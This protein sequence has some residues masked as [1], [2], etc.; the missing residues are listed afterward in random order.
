MPLY[1]SDS[2]KKRLYTGTIKNGKA[3]GYGKSVGISNGIEYTAEGFYTSETKST[4][5]ISGII[6]S[7]DGIKIGEC[8]DADGKLTG[9][10]MREMMRENG[11]KTIQFGNFRKDGFEGPNIKMKDT[12]K[13]RE[14]FKEKI[15][16]QKAKRLFNR[17]LKA[18]LQ[19]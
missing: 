3:D 5:M 7:K 1:D 16:D 12:V 11:K 6:K 8:F 2:Q 14:A 18:Y 19:A 4:K 10:G 15:E 13:D 17:K 9:P